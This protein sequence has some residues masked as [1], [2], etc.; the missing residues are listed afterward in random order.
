VG[1]L[2]VGLSSQLAN[3]KSQ[4]SQEIADLF[5]DS[6]NVAGSL[7]GALAQASHDYDL[8]ESSAIVAQMS[9]LS[10]SLNGSNSAPSEPNRDTPLPEG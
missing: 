4:Y 3:L 5:Y 6:N 10:V 2:F 1:S 7:E 9:Q 8:V